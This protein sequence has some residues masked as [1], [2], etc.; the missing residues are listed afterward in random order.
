MRVSGNLQGRVCR[1]RDEPVLSSQ[2]VCCITRHQ[3]PGISAV[4][5]DRVRVRS[6]RLTVP[7]GIGSRACLRK[8]MIDCGLTFQR[9]RRLSQSPARWP[10]RSQYSTA[11]RSYSRKSAASSRLYPCRRLSVSRITLTLVRYRCPLVY[12]HPDATIP[13]PRCHNGKGTDFKGSLMFISARVFCRLL[14]RR[15]LRPPGRTSPLREW[16]LRRRRC[17]R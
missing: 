1:P 17:C 12:V 4:A 5:P 6:A 10:I 7:V 16:S 11:F 3:P 9:A 2:V 13:V 15:R 14:S 8:S